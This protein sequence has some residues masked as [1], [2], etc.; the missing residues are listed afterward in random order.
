MFR[1]LHACTVCGTKDKR[2][3]N[4]HGFCAICAAKKREWN[5]KHRDLEAERA[6]DKARR[7]KR[8]EQGLC[9]Y[10]GGKRDEPDKMLC[11]DCRVKARM[12]K[13]KMEYKKLGVE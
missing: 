2:T 8:R 6:Y 9:T 1:K 4:G 13:R 12:K 5:R 10:C 11:T 7:D 3:V